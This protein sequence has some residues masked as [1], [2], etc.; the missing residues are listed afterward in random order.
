MMSA[1][2][3]VRIGDA[4][5][6]VDEVLWCLVCA[7]SVSV[8][9][10]CGK[11]APTAQPTANLANTSES[12]ASKTSAP[13]QPVVAE[14][15]TAAAQQPA[16]GDPAP[17][18]VPAPVPPSAEQIAKWAIPDYQ[19]L[20]LVA[21]WD[22]FDDTFLQA[23]AVSPD[24]KQFA[25]AGA[26]LTLWNT[27]EGEPAVDLTKELVGKFEPPMRDVAIS[28]D[29]KWLAAGDQKGMLWIWSLS[30]TSL[31]VEVQAHKSFLA[32]LAFSPDSA[33][34]ATT[35]YSGEISFW[36]TA[37]GKPI[38]TQKVGTQQIS[39]MIFASDKT[40]AVVG[41]TAS[42]WNVESGKE[43]QL[44]SPQYVRAAGLALTPDGKLFYG[45]KEGQAHLRDLKDG[46]AVT[47]SAAA[48]NAMRADFSS[49]GKLLA[50]VNSGANVCI[51]EAATGRVLQVM[52]ANASRPVGLQWIPETNLLLIATDNGRVRLW[53]TPDEAK[54]YGLEPLELP[55][56]P[57]LAADARVPATTAQIE[58][59]I[60]LRSLPALP[61]ADA[62][63][64]RAAMLSYQTKAPAS[65]VESFYRHVLGQ[66][67]WTQQP[68]EGAG[69]QSLSF[70]KEGCLLNVSFTQGAPMD[71][72]GTSV[73]LFLSGNYDSRWLPKLDAIEKADSYDFYATVGYRSKAN[74]TDIEVELLKKLHAAGW[75]P[76]TRLQASSSEQ[77]DARSMSLVRNGGE[78]TLSIGRPA[79]K[80]DEYFVQTSVH[81]AD[82]SLPIPPDSGWIEFDSSTDL[83]LVA[84]TKLKLEE[85][86]AFYDQQMAAEGWLA[87]EAG[88]V[89]DE[90][91]KRAWSPYIRGQRDAIIGF[92]SLDDGTTRITVGNPEK[93][94]WQLQKPV[95]EN[96]QLAEDGIEVADW[97]LPKEAQKVAYD[98]DEKSVQ[99]QVP[100]VKLTVLADTIAKQLSDLGWQ[101]ETGGIADEEYVLARFKKGSADL[102]LRIRVTDGNA[103]ASIS[104]KGLLWNK[105]LPAPPQAVS[106][107]T[108]LR[109]NRY[110]ATLDR[111]DDFADEMR[112][113]TVKAERE[114]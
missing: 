55:A 42:L 110:P 58:R 92:Q 57:G 71:T 114:E 67:G 33:Q 52:D 66:R 18:K 7:L 46:K 86:I 9:A 4:M 37:T 109:R 101:K 12:P 106:Y 24:G 98:V 62:A 107:G 93:S 35:S 60:D 31:V 44:L 15:S 8:L 105:P 85:A 56:I 96:P 34:V 69:P 5:R 70:V 83:M 16:A 21:C 13:Q 113:L 32:K 108:W 104:G 6:R 54:K 90:E 47:L 40:L 50:I 75:T 65:E 76:Y 53:G 1:M 22:E 88:R 100:Q 94:S 29:G 97:P 19:P 3:W 23:L 111:L 43:E 103:A 102:D 81:V 45:D 112:K 2:R 84:N 28:P 87:R 41:G 91:N 89:V 79:G 30:D 74:L 36:E 38:A 73:N 77:P 82:G 49:D 39:G 68:Q 26:R 99:F 59:L 63:M 11:A 20:Q 17:K 80:T 14:Q 72:A 10:G 25:L 61:D 51:L 95:V 64:G 78:M 27:G 48:G